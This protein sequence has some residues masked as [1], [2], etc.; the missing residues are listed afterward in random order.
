MT[1]IAIETTSASHVIPLVAFDTLSR[2]TEIAAL[3]TPLIDNTMLGRFRVGMTWGSQIRVQLVRQ[4]LGEDAR[5][6]ARA[7]EGH[8]TVG[9][10]GAG[11]CAL[12]IVASGTGHTSEDL[13]DA[14]QI[15]WHDTLIGELEVFV[16]RLITVPVK[17]YFIRCVSHAL[18]SIEQHT[19]ADYP[20]RFSAVT[21]TTPIELVNRIWRPAGIEFTLPRDAAGQNMTSFEGDLIVP[22]IP[23]SGARVDDPSDDIGRFFAAA[24]YDPN[25]L[26][27]YMLFRVGGWR[28]DRLGS[29]Y[30]LENWPGLTVPSAS[31]PCVIIP[32]YYATDGNQFR[33]MWGADRNKLALVLAHEFGHYLGLQHPT[34][35]H[36]RDHQPHFSKRFLMDNNSDGSFL[37]PL[38]PE[39]ERLY[40]D[41]NTFR[42]DSVEMARRVASKRYG[43]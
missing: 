26:N 27:L 43:K 36:E 12:T 11:N 15:Y 28:A 29:T 6:T 34:D 3:D 42:D 8:V 16:M 30:P 4:G 7:K 19:L 13:W 32:I 5:L 22:G 31:R 25:V 18:S 9:A 33:A 38:R 35:H 10:V 37:I 41:A 24:P 39:G 20:L 14:V 1:V 40:G 2:R 23:E 17:A 21:L